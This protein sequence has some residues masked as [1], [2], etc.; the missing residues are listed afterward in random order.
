[1]PFYLPGSGGSFRRSSGQGYALPSDNHRNPEF[2]RT[3][4]L[5]NNDSGTPGGAHRRLRRILDNR[6]LTPFQ[7]PSR[8]SESRP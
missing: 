7:A 5:S 3:D 8:C 6:R 2:R 4:Y 1:W